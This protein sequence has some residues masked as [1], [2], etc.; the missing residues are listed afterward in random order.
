MPTN[1]DDFNDAFD[2][3]ISTGEVVAIPAA[4]MTAGYMRHDSYEVSTALMCADAYADS[5]MVDLAVKAITR[6]QRPLDVAAGGTFTN[7]FFNGGKS[8]LK[9]SSFPSGHAAGA[10]SVATVVADALSQSPL[11]AVG[12]VRFR[13]GDQ[14][15]S[16]HHQR[17]F[18]VR[19]VSRR[20][21][22]LYHHALPGAAAAMKI[23]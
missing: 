4:L 2:P 12:S 13:D 21:A 9:G 20:G 6:R 19:R 1:L 5:A 7:T 10:F 3:Y 18:S 23:C 16:H 22:R 17:S 11:G 8:P 14:L 15:V